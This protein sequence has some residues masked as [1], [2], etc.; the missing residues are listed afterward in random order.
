MFVR[1]QFEAPGMHAGNHC[2]RR[3]IVHVRDNR[4][5]EVQIPIQLVMGHGLSRRLLVGSLV[6]DVGKS[7]RTKQLVGR[8]LR[9]KAGD[10][11]L[12]KADRGD[13]RR[14]LG[15]EGPG[16]T[17]QPGSANAAESSDTGGAE[18]VEETAPALHNRHCTPHAN[19]MI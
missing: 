1:E 5:C 4:R 11:S 7:L 8:I 16:P 6:T 14:R 13:F 18:V 12:F 17:A 15:G 19:R 3:A 2:D 9:R 10:R